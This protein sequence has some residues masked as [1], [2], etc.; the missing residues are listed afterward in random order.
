VVGVGDTDVLQ[1]QGVEGE[2]RHRWIEAIAGGG[3]VLT[4]GERRP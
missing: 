3:E 1:H 2:A 4:R